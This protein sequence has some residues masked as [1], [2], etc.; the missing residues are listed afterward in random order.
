M[1][2]ATSA[3][4]ATA[5]R[6]LIGLTP[7]LLPPEPRDSYPGKSLA[8]V[9][10][11]M[12][13]RVVAAGGLP[14]LLPLLTADEDVLALADRLDG[15]LLTGG[16]DLDPSSWGSTDRRFPGQPERDR[17][18]LTLLTRVRARRRPVLGICR[19]H[20]LLNVAFGGTLI[21][22]IPSDHAGAGLHR[23]AVRYDTIRHS[24]SLPEDS[25]LRNL[26]DVPTDRIE[27][28][29]VHHQAIRQLGDGLLASAWSDDGLIEAIE[30]LSDAWTR[31]VQWHPEWNPHDPARDRLF[32]SFIAA[33]REHL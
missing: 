4:M 18:E 9:D 1:T 19:G 23:D 26:L 12:A 5:H 21:I 33:A 22:D 32:H 13:D 28:N 20:Q 10:Q 27:V 8:I 2:S 15:L 3:G 17:F 14:V 6:P 31:G 29:S 25:F 7:T 24:V 11:A 16:V 30:A